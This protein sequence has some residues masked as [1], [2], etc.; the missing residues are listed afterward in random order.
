MCNQVKKS[1]RTTES[2]ERHYQGGWV[3]PPSQG[4]WSLHPAS[5]CPGKHQDM[6]ACIRCP[7]HRGHWHHT[8]ARPRVRGTKD[9]EGS[10]GGICFEILLLVASASAI[11]SSKDKGSNLPAYSDKTNRNP[12]VF[13]LLSCTCDW[14][15]TSWRFLRIGKINQPF[16]EGHGWS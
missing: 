6:T 4:C 5:L 3:L 15:S 10:H 14:T 13:S 16:P 7:V 11:S 8:S 9:T 2:L 12:V 1:S